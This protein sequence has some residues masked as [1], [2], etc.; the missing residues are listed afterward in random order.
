MALNGIWSVARI[1]VFFL[2]ELHGLF[3]T[4][5]QIRFSRLK[6]VRNGWHKGVL[7]SVFREHWDT[8]TA[9]VIAW[10][11]RSPALIRRAIN[12]CPD[13]C[14]LCIDQ[15][16]HERMQQW[17]NKINNNWTWYKHVYFRLV[18]SWHLVFVWRISVNDGKSCE[19]CLHI[20]V[21]RES[22]GKLW[23]IRFIEQIN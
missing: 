10:F 17:I 22:F 14:A 1:L 15:Q 18:G 21:W 19:K 16:K 23:D 20:I 12:I 4:K 6:C 8:C 11:F 13:K 3:Y 2:Y 5:A 7:V 9:V